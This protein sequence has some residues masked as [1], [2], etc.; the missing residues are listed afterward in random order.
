MNEYAKEISKIPLLPD[1]ETGSL[2]VS[3]QKGDTEARK[4]LIKHNLRMVLN[5]ASR[6]QSRINLPI[7]DLISIGAFGLIKAVDNFDASRNAKL[8]TVAHRYIENAFNTHIYISKRKKRDYSTDVSLQEQIYESKDGDGITLEETIEDD[9]LAVDEV[10]I[11]KIR[12]E[13]LRKIL[14]RLTKDERELLLLRYGITD[15]ICHTLEDIAEKQGVTRARIGQK[16]SKALK[17]LKHP[18]ITRQVKGFLED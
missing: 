18:K 7:E 2:I 1:E 3:M 15:G 14:M 13:N 16:E 17:K 9:S 11:Q 6:F 5:I 4:K 10:I 8:S 12:D